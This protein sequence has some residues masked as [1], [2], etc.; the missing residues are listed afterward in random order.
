MIADQSTTTPHAARISAAAPLTVAAAAATAV[1]V[2]LVARLSGIDLR[3]TPPGQP[4]MVVTLPAVVGAALAAGL[5]GWATL[6]IL[7]R[8]TRHARTLWTVLAL[9]T[10]VASFAPIL[11]VQAGA[12]VRAVL[13]LMHVGVAAVLVPGL[14]RVAAP[15]GVSSTDRMGE[16]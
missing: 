2:W 1:L 6:A 4:P 7:R 13:A 11:S 15:H 5:A 14:R 8:V 10:L 9:A 16:S 3:V 12:G